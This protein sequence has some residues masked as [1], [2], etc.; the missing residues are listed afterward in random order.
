MPLGMI[1]SEQLDDY[2]SQNTRRKVFFSYPNGTAPLTG[3]LSLTDSED[4]PQP[5]FGWNEERWNQLRTTTVAG[6]TSN[7]VFYTTGTTTTAGATVTLTAGTN[8][9]IYITDASLF[10]TDDV[11][12]IH[13][14]T[15]NSSSVKTEASFRV[16]STNTTGTD[17]VEAECLG[18]TLAVTNNAAGVV[19]IPVVYQGTAYA[20]GSRSRTGRYKFPSEIINYTQIFK[21]P[22]EMT[23]TALKEPLKYD[24]SGAYKKDLKTNGIDHMAGIEW[25]FLFGDRRTTTATD[26]DTGQTVRRSF[27]GGLLWF[28]KQWEKGSVANGG[29]FNYRDNAVDV[30]TETDYETYTDKRIIRLGG[31]AVTRSQFNKIE[32]LAFRKTNSTEFCKLCLCGTDYFTKVNEAYEKQVQFTQLREEQFKGWEFELHMRSGPAGKVYYKTHPLFQGPEMTNSAFYIDLGFLGYRPL[33]D[34]DTDVQQLIQ[35]NDADKRKDQYLT[36]CG[37]ELQFAEAHSFVEDLGSI[38]LG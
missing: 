32:A 6:P 21:T 34:S 18:T 31:S 30:S 20:E 38:T 24:K 11:L 22:F 35:A 26:E 13:R 2:W 7:T 27:T 25:S 9:R 4:T 12:K 29:A 16:I 36:E 10:Q 33:T 14:L 17:Y 15:V 23:R 8:Y 5:Q 37:L 28:L 19:G 3:L 1:S